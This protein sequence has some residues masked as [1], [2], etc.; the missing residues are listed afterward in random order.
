MSLCHMFACLPLYT[1][2][3]IVG[4]R[5]RTQNIIASDCFTVTVVH[6]PHIRCLLLN[7]SPA[8]FS[9]AVRKDSALPAS[10]VLRCNCFVI[11]YV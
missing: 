1:C 2:M 8:W 11:D 9:F 4:G 5:L 6:N 10:A 7:P 3:S